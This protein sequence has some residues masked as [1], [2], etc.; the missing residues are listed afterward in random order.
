[1]FLIKHEPCK[2][3]EISI[4]KEDREYFDSP[5]GHSGNFTVNYIFN[6]TQKF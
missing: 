6:F 2:F 4:E 5:L 1:M 3:L